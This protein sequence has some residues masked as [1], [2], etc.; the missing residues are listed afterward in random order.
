MKIFL[1]KIIYIKIIL[2]YYYKKNIKIMINLININNKNWMKI[3]YKILLIYYKKYIK[4][5]IYNNC[6]K[7]LISHIKQ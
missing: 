1:I 3:N 2:I 6:N 4:K 7:L 5:M